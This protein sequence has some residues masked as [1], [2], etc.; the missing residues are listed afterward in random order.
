MQYPT[1]HLNGTSKQEL[2]DQACEAAQ[3]IAL[4]V[5]ALENAAPNARDYYPQSGDA[6]TLARSEH[7][8]RIKALVGVQTELETMIEIIDATGE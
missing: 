7:L 8:A 1:V 2:L 3:A 4:A 6:I 5:N